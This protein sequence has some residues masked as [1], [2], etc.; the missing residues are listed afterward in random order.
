MEI[1]HRRGAVAGVD[2]G[3][4]PVNDLTQVDRA[5]RDRLRILFNGSCAQDILDQVVERATH[6]IGV[7]QGVAYLL[8]REA[9]PPQQTGLNISLQCRKRRTE[10]V[11]DTRD[12]LVFQ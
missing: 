1:A 4:R 10:L 7:L 8:R 5:E 12:E 2:E 6:P 11:I 3:E 9:I